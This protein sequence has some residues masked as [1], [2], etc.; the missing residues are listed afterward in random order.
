MNS[1]DVVYRDHVVEQDVHH[2]RHIVESSGF[3]SAAE[4]ALAAELV[5]ERLIKGPESGYHFLFA[6]Q[7]G[8]VVGY[9]CFGPIACALSSYDLYWIAVHHAYRGQGL[10]K[11]MLQGTE[12]I[13]AARGGTR[14]YIET[15][16][17]PQ[18]E[19]TRKFYLACHYREEAFLE[20]FY[21]PGDGKAIYVKVLARET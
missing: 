11:A 13:I 18:Y 1:N 20:D 7:K 21:A 2:V 8:G 12:T 6:E 17:R 19:P 15:A 3:F 14:I 10:G 9:T 5:Q 4:I 16:S